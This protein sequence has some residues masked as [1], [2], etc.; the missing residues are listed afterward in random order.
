MF[1]CVLAPL[2]VMSVWMK[3]VLLDTDNYVSTVAPL[4]HNSDVQNAIANRVTKALPADGPVEQQVVNRLPE[5]AKFLGPKLADAFASVV[6]DA[7]QKVVQSDQFATLWENLN[8]RADT[9]IVALLEGKGTDTVQTKNGEVA[10]EIGP[11]VQ[12][13]NS[14]LEKKGITAF[15]GAASSASGKRIV[16]IKSTS[17]KNAQ[18]VTNLLQKLAVVLPILTLL[19]FGLAI[20]LSPRRRRTILRSGLG[21]ALGMALLL[22]AFNAG[23]HFYLDVLP[24]SVNANAA[25]AVYDQLI[26]TLRL[27]LRTGFVLALVVALA[28]W[29]AGPAR[30]ATSMR[31]GVLRFARGTGTAG[32]EA[33]P[34]G[35]YV[36]RH[37]NGL[38]VLVVGIGLAVLVALSAPSPL[39]VIVI[40][41]LM[42]LG[43]LLI[44]F[45]GRRVTPAPEPAA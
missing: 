9:Q 24:A 11:I 3:S 2:S 8:R 27:A 16:L 5:K 42:L 18:G 1:G 45:L 10:L 13:V 33:S 4:A 38:R 21:L 44:E 20:W 28:A 31:E 43:V 12:K 26:G 35:L 29:L 15:S 23:R 22:I 40:A 39:A 36:A 14:A 25:G 6:H 41:L 7:T 32:G 30:P 17:L 19:C 37:K 34:L